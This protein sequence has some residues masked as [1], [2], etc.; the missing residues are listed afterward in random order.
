[1]PHTVLHK[2]LKQHKSLPLLM[3]EPC[4]A[5]WREFTDCQVLKI[6]PR[7]KLF[8]LENT[9]FGFCILHSNI[10]CNHLLIYSKVTTLE[11]GHH[12]NFN[13]QN[14][15]CDIYHYPHMRF[16]SYPRGNYLIRMK[17]LPPGYY[18]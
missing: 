17:R 4:D 14:L 18:G 11:C 3:Q 5:V 12:I 8:K 10:L 15:L 16:W 13:K 1:M 2:G 6:N 9:M 7:V